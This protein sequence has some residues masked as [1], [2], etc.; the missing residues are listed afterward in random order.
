[1]KKTLDYLLSGAM[2]ALVILLVIFLIEIQSTGKIS[3]ASI[4]DVSS[5]VTASLDMS[6]MQP[7]DSNMVKRLYGLN[8]S[9]YDGLVLYY[10]VT[11]MDAQELLIVKLHDTSQQE[12]VAAAVEARVAAQKKSFDG[13]GVE[14]F[15]LLEDSITEISGNYVLFIAHPNAKDV[16]NAFKKAL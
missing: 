11:N 12:T 13:Y 8:P 16:L 5:A 15:A 2:A 14:Q 9:D 4:E 10:P 1:M 7:A 6:S 3:D